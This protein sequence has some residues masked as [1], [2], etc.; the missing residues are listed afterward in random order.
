LN[1]SSLHLKPE[2]ALLGVGAT[3]AYPISLSGTRLYDSQNTILIQ[4][5]SS[6]TNA[7]ANAVSANTLYFGSKGNYLSTSSGYTVPVQLESRP[8]IINTIRKS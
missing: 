2:N 6:V 8:V 7:I 5:F 3:L 1:V 4:L